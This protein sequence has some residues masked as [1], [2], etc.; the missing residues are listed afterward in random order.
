MK[1]SKIKIKNF[2]G[3]K[4]LQLPGGSYELT[5]VNGA[6]KSTVIDAIRYAITNRS[7]RPDLVR[8]G[9]EEGEI[10][11]E[12]DTGLSIHRKPR[13][14]K[15]DYK[16]IKQ[17]RTPVQ[18]PEGLLAEIFTP[19]QINPVEFLTYSTEKQ[20]RMILDTI[21]YEWTMDTIKEWFGEIPAWV[22]YSQSILEILNQIQSEKGQYYQD[23][24]EINRQIRDKRAN[25]EEIGATIPTNYNLEYW[26]N[27]SLGDVYTK[28]EKI[29]K[30]NE[31]I[32]RA[33]RVIDA[34]DQQVRS[35]EAEKEIA[36]SALEK[37]ASAA[38]LRYEKEIQQLQAELEKAKGLLGSIGE[39]KAQKTKLIEADFREKTAK[40]DAE[41]EQYSEI[42]GKETQD[43]S[44]LQKEA[45]SAE[46]M[47]SHINEYRR[48]QRLEKEREEL[49]L[50]SD[51]LTAKIEKARTL[52]GQILEEATIPV[53]G[54]T[55]VDGIPRIRGRQVASLSD[56]EKLQLCVDIAVAKPTNLQII[57]LDE[58]SNLSTDNRNALYEKC[59]AKGLQFIATRTTDDSELIITEL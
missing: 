5:G 56:G 4:E 48:M 19:L 27:Y 37:E 16:S 45:Q 35:F 36:L 21:E 31:L 59:K 32:E 9:A 38:T 44:E 8:D 46:E 14:N 20:N 7:D 15:S 18:A 25:I 39:K 43:Y 17:G 55:I 3:I 29:R 6:G 12:T 2:I 42:A 11:I 1:I 51:A 33:R 50:E 41:V 53:E 58:I 28:I 26:E 40:Y 34:R 47:K 49:T 52:P 23:R 22:D 57:L 54:L 13:I 30:E 10:L 24:W